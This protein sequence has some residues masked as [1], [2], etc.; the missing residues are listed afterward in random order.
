MHPRPVAQ[1]APTILLVVATIAFGAGNVLAKA[2]LDRG[3]PPLTL[4]PIRYAFALGSLVLMLALV[5]RLRFYDR[6]AWMKGG[7]IG[8]V[9]VGGPS[10]LMTMGLFHLSASVAA[11]ML[12]LIPLVTVFFA[13]HLV[14]GEPMRAAI[15]PGF[16][17]ALIGVGLL[18]DA[19][20]PPGTNPA[21]GY[22]LFGLGVITAGAGGALTR[23]FAL[24]TPAARLVLPQFVAAALAV[25]V[26]ALATGSLAGVTR[27]DPGSWGLL[28]TLGIVATTVAFGALLWLSEMATAARTAL[29]AYLVP[30]VGV[31]GGVL[32]LGDPVSGRLLLGG[33]LILA[34][35]LAAERAERRAHVEAVVGP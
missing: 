12:A 30:L 29:V 19:G 16:I 33:V 22:L 31:A 5:G 20:G 2:I 32:I 21:L 26:T 23:R 7:L 27:I 34:G 28:I 14:E 35:V 1:H 3:V 8:V 4:L 10:I 15:L 11:L 25:T 17:L 9:N 6:G 13:H 24:G 18:V